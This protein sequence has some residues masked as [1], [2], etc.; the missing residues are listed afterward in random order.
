MHYKSV[1][2]KREP[3]APKEHVSAG[4]KEDAQAAIK[5]IQGNCVCCLH[6]AIPGE[7][8]VGAK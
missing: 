8:C 7:I 6:C 2:R 3:K 4:E 1:E 5:E